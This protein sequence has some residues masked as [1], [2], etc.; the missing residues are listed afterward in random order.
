MRVGIGWDVHPFREGKKLILGGV[1]IPYK[2][3]L[4]GWSDA[5][6][7]LHSLGDALLGA[8]GKKDLGSLFPD[9]EKKFK[10]VSSLKLLRE[11]YSLLKK[12]GFRVN[13]VDVTLVMEK[14]KIS[15]WVEKMKANISSI[16]KIPPSSVSIKATTQEGLGFVGRE[17]GVGCLSVVSIEKNGS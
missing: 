9:K 7:L 16:L 17:E 4:C 2:R 10:G 15:P 12:E 1:S 6:V 5:D 14:P 3:G 8:A 13:N 11:I